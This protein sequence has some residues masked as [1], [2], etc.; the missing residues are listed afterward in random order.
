MSSPT[1][2]PV[3]W[4]DFPEQFRERLG[5]TAGSQRCMQADGHLLIVAHHVPEPDQPQRRGILFW[6]DA[7]GQWRASN[8]DPGKSALSM[9]LDRFAKRL[10]RYEIEEQKA[11]Q[12]LD[13]LPVLDG[14]VPLMRTLKNLLAAL[15][16]ARDLCPAERSLIETR[17]RAYD[18]SRQAEL[19]HTDVKN[20]MEVAM[21]RNA[22]EQSA[23]AQQ[24]TVAAHRLNTL[25][26]LFL[27]IATLGT[28]LGT[29]LTENWRWSQSPIYFLLLILVGT[30]LGL[31]VSK[32]INRPYKP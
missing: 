4:N 3:T 5:S 19:L 18:L 22:A 14:I 8:G 12:S 28:V 31:A 32:F 11:D 16:H 23:A 13:Y 30:A 17:D 24:M 29:T 10:E 6:L 2:I 15:E 21:I 27:P 9:H 7:T 20:S 25:A 1:L 26:A